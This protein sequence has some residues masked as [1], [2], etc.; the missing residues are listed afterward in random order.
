MWLVCVEYVDWGDAVNDCGII[1]ENQIARLEH[2]P[3]GFSRL[4]AKFADASVDIMAVDT[5]D[6]DSRH[7]IAVPPFDRRVAFL[8]W[9]AC[10]T[11]SLYEKTGGFGDRGLAY[12]KL[13]ELA[14]FFG[15]TRE[16]FR[17]H[18]I[19]ISMRWIGVDALIEWL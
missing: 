18:A 15:I 2:Y 4:V 9:V 17:I 19:Y 3:Y 6:S 16:V 10:N 12:E 8:V 7:A 5:R 13:D 11:L 14:E 1:K